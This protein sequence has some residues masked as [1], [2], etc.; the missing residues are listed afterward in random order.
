MHL[1]MVNLDFNVPLRHR[2][3]L[4]G[5]GWKFPVLFGLKWFVPVSNKV[6]FGTPY[7]SGLPGY[8]NTEFLTMPLSILTFPKCKKTPVGVR[9]SSISHKLEGLGQGEEGVLISGYG[10]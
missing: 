7:A 6:R 8:K 9:E 10:V 2:F 3:S 4:T 5:V 1:L